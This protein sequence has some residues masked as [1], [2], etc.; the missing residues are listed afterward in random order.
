MTSKE[1]IAVLT[2]KHTIIGTT[3]CNDNA[4]KKLKPAID[5]AITAL[6][7]QIPTKPYI[8]SDGFGNEEMQCYECPNCDSFIGYVGDCVD[9]HY[10]NNYCRF[11]GQAIDWD[12]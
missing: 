7:K 5:T 1:A 4:W 2:N 3:K 8:Q 6:E 11:C 9:E 12:E 10:Q